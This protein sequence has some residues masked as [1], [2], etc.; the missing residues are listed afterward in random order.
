MNELNLLENVHNN[1]TFPS[2]R[3]KLYLV[4]GNYQYYHYLCDKHDDRVGYV[5][6]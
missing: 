5:S 4:K 1:L 3:G 2:D 6:L